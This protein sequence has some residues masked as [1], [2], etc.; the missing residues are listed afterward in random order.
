VHAS[1]LPGVYLELMYGAAFHA[2]LSNGSVAFLSFH[3]AR[4]TSWQWSYPYVAYFWPPGNLPVDTDSLS[5]IRVQ[6]CPSPNVSGGAT[7]SVARLI[8]VRLTLSR[9]T[10]KGTPMLVAQSFEPLCGVVNIVST[11]VSNSGQGSSSSSDTDLA[12][13]LPEGK[14]AT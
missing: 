4:T 5:N 14:P 6:T 7:S 3:C 9:V 8:G 10:E 2:D 13:R 11:S 1:P 12:S